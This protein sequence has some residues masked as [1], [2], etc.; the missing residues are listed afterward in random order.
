MSTANISRHARKLAVRGLPWTVSDREL[1]KYFSAFGHV[2]RAVVTFNETT[3]MSRGFG[4]VNF[5]SAN[6]VERCWK[7][8]IH[9]L[10]GRVIEIEEANIQ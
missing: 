2:D 5:G 8:K 1:K 6:A 9:Y 7:Q 3:G 10:E 4:F